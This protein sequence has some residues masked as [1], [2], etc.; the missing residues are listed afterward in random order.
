MDDPESPLIYLPGAPTREEDPTRLA[1][2]WGRVLSQALSQAKPGRVNTWYLLLHVND[3]GP[4][5]VEDFDAW[6]ASGAWEEEKA[7]LAIALQESFAP[8]QDR[9]IPSVPAEMSRDYLAWEE[10]CT[11]R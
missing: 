10:S 2:F 11:T 9:L 1:P 6:L 5:P 4:L 3:F 7:Q 8:Y